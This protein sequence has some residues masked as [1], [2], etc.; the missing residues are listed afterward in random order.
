MEI[1]R[2][3]KD[4]YAFLSNFYECTVRYNGRTF[5]SSEAAFHAEKC[6]NDSEKDKFIGLTPSESKKT[7]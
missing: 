4:D 3:F 7:W 6:L 5:D 2:E 1:I